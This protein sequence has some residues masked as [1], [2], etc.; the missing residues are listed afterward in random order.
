LAFVARAQRSAVEWV[1]VH[2][3]E[4]TVTFLKALAAIEEPQLIEEGIS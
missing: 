2:D 1:R 3:V 4:E